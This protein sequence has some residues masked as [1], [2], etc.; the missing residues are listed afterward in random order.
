[1]LKAPSKLISVHI[2]PSA[3]DYGKTRGLFDCFLYF[4]LNL[5]LNAGTLDAISL[6]HHY[7][8][9]PGF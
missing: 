9:W 4:M 7:R 2:K 3:V 8:A 5:K 1:M 6:C